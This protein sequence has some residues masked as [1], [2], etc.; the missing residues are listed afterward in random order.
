MSLVWFQKLKENLS[1][2]RGNLLIL[3]L[4]WVLWSPAT[5]MVYTYE[6]VY[7]LGL[8]ADEFIMGMIYG[9]S[10]LILC[11]VRIPGGFIADR[12]GRKWIIVIMSFAAALTYL[13]YA[14]A[15]NWQWIFVAAIL[16]S[17]AL[18]YQPA[19]MA[20]FADSIPPERRGRGYALSNFLPGI[21]CVFAPS[22]AGYF[23][24]RRGLVGGMR[25]IYLL[26]FGSGLMTAFLRLFFL[27]ETLPKRKGNSEEKYSTTPWRGYKTEYLAAL[28]FVFRGV[29]I[30]LLLY[31]IVE[32]VSYGSLPFFVVFATGFLG[33]STEDLWIIFMVS[34]AIYLIAIMP[35]GILTDRVGRRKMLILSISIFILSTLLLI[36]TIPRTPYAMLCA[37]TSYALLQLAVAAS[38]SAL[39]AFEADLIPRLR[40][41]NVM[42]TLMLISGITTA[43]ATTIGGLGYKEITPYFPFFISMT[44]LLTGFPII[45]FRIRE[46]SKREI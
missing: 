29:P 3:T 1:Y 38:D 33:V 8:G 11:V 26:A 7:I 37:L 13:P 14:Y 41:G 19:L 2:F 21:F 39:P 9:I 22:V 5:V 15:P 12:F 20:A 44:L 24:L 36:V 17:M 40:R 32:F 4:S 28:K 18:V 6:P 25:L 10:T 45:F 43:I 27:K 16:S 42:A 34:Q 35:M 23:V 46:P 31:I 30:L